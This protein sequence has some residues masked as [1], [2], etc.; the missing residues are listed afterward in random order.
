M[1]SSRPSAPKL[2]APQ[3]EIMVQATPAPT[4]LKESSEVNSF[5]GSS[6]TTKKLRRGAGERKKKTKPF[7]DGFDKSNSVFKAYQDDSP[8]ILDQMFELD[9][10]YGKIS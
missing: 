10:K 8:Q 5:Q 9:Y 2:Q 4:P 1:K 7:N 6:V 3:S